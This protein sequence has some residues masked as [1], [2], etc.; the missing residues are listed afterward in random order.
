MNPKNNKPKSENIFLQDIFEEMV[1]TKSED[2]K[3]VK[4]SVNKPS[5]VKSEPRPKDLNEEVSHKKTFNEITSEVL[6]K[7]GWFDRFVAKSKGR[8]QELGANIKNVAN[9]VKTG[10]SNIKNVATG[11]PTTSQAEISNPQHENLKTTIQSIYKAGIID[12][13]EDMAKLGLISKT[14]ISKID[15]AVR[16][17]LSKT[18]TGILQGEGKID[19]DETLVIKNA[20]G[21]TFIT[22]NTPKPANVPNTPKPSNTPKANAPTLG[23]KPVAKKTTTIP[24]NRPANKPKTP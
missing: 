2:V 21:D 11:N 1:K 23:G 6:V 19:N 14:N 4:E 15:H 18:I 13:I 8:G 3:I 7:E 9:V 5:K 17:V 12:A 10:A 24:A 20:N 22:K 16:D